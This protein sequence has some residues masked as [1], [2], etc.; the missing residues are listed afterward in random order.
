MKL[1][2]CR[3]P[4]EHFKRFFGFRNNDPAKKFGPLGFPLRFRFLEQVSLF[5]ILPPSYQLD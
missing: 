5:G 3:A 4:K 1:Q 2:I